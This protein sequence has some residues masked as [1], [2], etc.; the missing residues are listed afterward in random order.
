MVPQTRSQVVYLAVVT[1]TVDSH[2]PTVKRQSRVS[3]RPQRFVCM[4]FFSNMFVVLK[5]KKVQTAQK[6]KVHVATIKNNCIRSN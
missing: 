6:L 1:Y 3:T 4:I 2:G 5:S